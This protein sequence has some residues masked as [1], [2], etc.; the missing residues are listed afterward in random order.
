MAKSSTTSENWPSKQLLHHLYLW[1][2]SVIISASH[3]AI[4]YS[5]PF[6]YPI[7]T[8]S[9]QSIPDWH[10]IYT[11]F[12]HYQCPICP[13]WWSV[14]NQSDSYSL[15]VNG[16]S[17]S[18]SLSLHNTQTFISL[19]VSPSL[20]YLSFYLGIIFSLS[21]SFSILVF[22]IIPSLS[23]PLYLA[24]FLFHSHLFFPSL[25]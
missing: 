8:W 4:L 7:C 17:W 22:G 19:S 18:D 2:P 10:L 24:F 20:L 16:R 25:S 21:H 1:L 6:L 11:R 23:F 12:A 5:L 3:T 15:L 14:M 9:A 13:Q